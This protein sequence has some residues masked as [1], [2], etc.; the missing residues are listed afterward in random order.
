MARCGI[1]FGASLAPFHRLGDIPTLAMA[2]DIGPIM[3]RRRMEESL[4]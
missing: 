3:L 2:R 1:K 4:G